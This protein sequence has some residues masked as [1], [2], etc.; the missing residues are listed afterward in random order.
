MPCATGASYIEPGSPWQNPWIESFN[1]RLREEV[2]DTEAFS[3]LA[4]AKLILAEW[5]EGSN[6]HPTF[7]VISV[8]GL[9][10]SGEFSGSPWVS[11]R[12]CLQRSLATNAASVTPIGAKTALCPGPSL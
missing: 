9:P 1:A 11:S 12:N 5:L 2:L 4:E 10:C 3:S 6:N 8:G 7:S